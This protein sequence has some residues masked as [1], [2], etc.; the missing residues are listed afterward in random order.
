MKQETYSFADVEAL[1]S[2]AADTER[3]A[4]D[5]DMQARYAAALMAEEHRIR[6]R[7][8][9]YRAGKV[10]AVLIMAAGIWYWQLES[11]P[12]PPMAVKQAAEAAP[13]T[14]ATMRVAAVLPALSGQ[15]EYAAEPQRYWASSTGKRRSVMRPGG[16][17]VKLYK[18]D[19]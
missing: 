16:F 9:L 13:A 17:T 12:P 3:D 10:A 1:L 19:L 6:C 2:K 15:A 4:M 11:S 7:S 18:V 14:P 8:Y 5:A